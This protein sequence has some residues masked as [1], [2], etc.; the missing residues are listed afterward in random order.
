MNLV[1]LLGRL[2]KD[3]QV[4]TTS[5][6]TTIASYTIAVD[7]NDKEKGVTKG[8]DY[9]DCTTFGAKAEFAGKYFKK[10]QKVA[11]IGEWHVDRIKQQDG[12]WKYY[13][14]CVLSSQEFAGTKIQPKDTAEVATFETSEE[15]PVL[16]SEPMP[17]MQSN[18]DFLNI[19][20]DLDD[21]VPFA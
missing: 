14:K 7:R 6:G 13:Q 4:K 20:D 5:T 16:T 3:P 11:V 10:G 15:G 9:I 8:S 19:P 12:T 18:D 17:K 2:V 1:I 21:E